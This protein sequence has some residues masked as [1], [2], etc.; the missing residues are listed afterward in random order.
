MIKKRKVNEKTTVLTFSDDDKD[1][2]EET[3]KE[4]PRKIVHEQ[5]RP[6]LASST[7]PKK[8]RI[9]NE[10]KESFD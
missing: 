9:E 10:V 2:Q 1:K 5:H 8:E 4:A 7:V 6:V 3:G